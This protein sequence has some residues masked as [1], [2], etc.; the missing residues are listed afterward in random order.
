MA[1]DSDGGYV[2]PLVRKL[3]REHDVDLSTVTGHRRRR[4]G[5]QAG[6]AGRRR[7]GRQGRRGGQA[8]RRRRGA[9]AAEAPAAAPAPAASQPAAAARR[10]PSRAGCAGTTEKMSRLRQT[11][12]RRMVESLQVSAQ[13]TATVE[14]DLT[15]ISRIRARAK[16]DFKR[17]EGASLSY[18][19]FIT[20]AAVEAL[21]VYPKVNA[22]IDTEAG[23]IT[24]PERR[25]RRHRGGHR[26]GPARPGDQGRRR[27]E[28]RRPG[29]E[30]RRPGR[31]HAAATR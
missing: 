15:A 1:G 3:A 12:A 8:G 31:P 17:R 21:K 26:E 5:P 2:T 13:L 25:A 16:D 27:P 10:R 23:E 4:P 19:P 7:G 28:H 14:V 24:Y 18:L 11:I 30:D 29:Q 20:K 9:K 22:T 6:R